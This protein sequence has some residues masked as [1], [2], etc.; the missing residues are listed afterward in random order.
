MARKRITEADIME[1]RQKADEL[2][3]ELE[4]KYENM[5]KSAKPVEDVEERELGIL[6]LYSADV[7]QAQI[8]RF[9]SSAKRAG[10][11]VETVDVS[12][13]PEDHDPRKRVPGW[14]TQLDRA[15][16]GFVL[17]SDRT[18]RIAIMGTGEAVPAA[19][20]LAEQYPVDALIIVGEGP[21]LR[22]FNPDRTLSKLAVLAKNNLFSVVCPVYAVTAG[23][24]GPFKAGSARMFEASSRS[25]NVQIEE[26]G[27]ISAAQMW[28]E[29]EQMLENRI[30][31]YL[32]QL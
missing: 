11:A 25:G 7:D 1:Y 17:L 28:T 27:G 24:P 30:F 23:I 13:K 16:T 26:E 12:L 21:A 18:Q 6:L 15:Q 4:I 20:V 14:Q 32:D 22:P 10:Y 9:S 31:A 5:E 2:Y 29:R 19:C 8:K 3:R